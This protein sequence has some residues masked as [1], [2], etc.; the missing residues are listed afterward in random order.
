M[1]TNAIL[2]Q[3]LIAELG[4]AFGMLDY[5][6]LEPEPLITGF[7]YGEVIGPS[8]V[9][10]LTAGIIEVAFRGVMQR[11]SYS[12]GSWGWV[13]VAV[14]YSMY[15]MRHGSA[16]HCLFAFAVALCFGWIVK[17]T[18]SVLGVSVA[19]CMMSYSLYLVFPFVF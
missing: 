11:V 2:V 19:H 1:N 13:C 16:L 5:L 17:G 9:L 14:I 3:T 15:E 18:G 8:I 4:I 10:M 7:T 6:I 12:L